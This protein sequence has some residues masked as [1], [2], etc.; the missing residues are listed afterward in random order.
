MT[1]EIRV[2]Q[3]MNKRRIHKFKNAN[4]YKAIQ[5]E[6]RI[7]KRALEDNTTNSPK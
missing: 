4:E 2:L 7:K 5:K 1:E 3:L 6:I